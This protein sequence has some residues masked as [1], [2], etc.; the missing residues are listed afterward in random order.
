MELAPRAATG[1][2]VRARRRHS[3]P[4]ADGDGGEAARCRRPAYRVLVGDRRRQRQHD[5]LPL[6]IDRHAHRAV[7][8]SEQTVQPKPHGH[9]SG[10]MLGGEGVV[11]PAYRAR[12]MIVEEER[13]NAHAHLAHARRDAR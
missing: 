4:I 7:H 9:P 3:G 6:L 5:P 12:L 13:T 1:H 11:R 2:R 10:R 8:T